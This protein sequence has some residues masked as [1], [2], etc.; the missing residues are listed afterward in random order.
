MHEKQRTNGVTEILII[1]F[2]QKTKIL[3]IFLSIVISV[4][5]ATLMTTPIYQSQTKLLVKLGR[6][7]IFQNETGKERLP[8]FIKKEEVLN[9]EVHILVSEELLENAIKFIGMQAIYPELEMNSFSEEVALKKAVNKFKKDLS[10]YHVRKSDV[11]SVNYRHKNPQI[12]AFVLNNLI[13]VYTERHLQLFSNSRTDFFGNQLEIYRARM[14]ETSEIL[15]DFKEKNKVFS[16]KEQ[17]TFL[18]RQYDSLDIVWKQAQNRIQELKQ[19]LFAVEKQMEK[20]PENVIVSSETTTNYYIDT[21]MNKLLNLQLEE[22]QL[23]VKYDEGNRLVSS[24]RKE[25]QL[26]RDFISETESLSRENVRVGRNSI[27]QQ[28]ENNKIN[29]ESE[30]TALKA[31]SGAIKRQL[32]LLEDEIKSFDAK[33]I[34]LNSITREL[35]ATE[36]NYKDFLS[37]YEQAVLSEEMDRQKLANVSVIQKALVPER[38]VFPKKRS[39]IVMAIILGGATSLGI[40]LF[41][42]FV[43][44]QSMST[45]ES[46]ERRLGIPVLTTIAYKER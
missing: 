40:A 31:K 37:K 35:N 24:I 36:D 30:L 34:M 1:L 14:Q 11:I 32:V 7:Y 20:V 10:V 38:P 16:I 8:Q 27:Y 28:L 23:L 17:R 18:L 2:K 4:T 44:E 29:F 13:D 26:V 25:I 33:E 39:N 21:A 15:K 43:I 19:M 46:V 12:A 22:Q 45:P 42:E 9:T 5:V 3:I 41:I 6:E